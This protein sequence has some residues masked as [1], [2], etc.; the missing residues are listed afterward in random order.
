[1]I[2]I[3]LLQMTKESFNGQRCSTL[4]IYVCI[5]S[6]F[7]LNIKAGVFKD[8]R[9]VLLS[10]SLLN[11]L[12]TF[13]SLIR[14]SFFEFG[15][16]LPYSWGIRPSFFAAGQGIRQKIARVAGISSLKKKFPRAAR[17]GCTQ[18]ELTETLHGDVFEVIQFSFQL[19][20]VYLIVL[21]KSFKCRLL[22][23][24]SSQG[25]SQVSGR[26]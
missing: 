12:R 25:F 21:L 23:T 20:S 13:A 11:V 10:G 16:I 14:S 26:N 4:Y 22:T 17:E 15:K 3:K 1:M 7:L 9:V 5:Y 19:S 24:D 18:W 8:F 6:L 2:H